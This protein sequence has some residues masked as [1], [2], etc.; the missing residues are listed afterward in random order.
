MHTRSKVKVAGG[1]SALV[2]VLSACASGSSGGSTAASSSGAASSCAKGSGPIVIASVTDLSGAQSP[3]GV[4]ENQGVKL[5]AQE[6][7]DAGGLLGGRKI[8][9]QNFDTQTSPD[10]GVPQATAAVAAKPAAIIGGEISD[11][12]IAGTNISHR[13]GIPWL[14]PGGTA[15]QITGRGFTDVFQ[16]NPN[17]T[18]SAQGYHDVMAFV[19]DKLGVGNK[20]SISVSDTTYGQNL[21]A[22]FTAINDKS[23]KFD[24]V[25]KVSY[26]LSTTDLS[27]IATRMVQPAPDILYNEGYPADGV[28]LGGLF[29]DKVNTTAKVYL[30]T[31]A[32]ATVLKTLGAKANGMLLLGVMDP[33]VKG[34]P[35]SFTDFQD[36]YLKAYPSPNGINGQ[37]FSG[38]TA[39]R[40]VEQAIK[41]AGCADPAEVA[42]ALH[43]VKL[44][45]TTGNI[46]P[47]DEL[48]FDTNGA[49]S[50]PPQFY[51]QVQDGKAVVIYPSSVAT[52]TPIPYRG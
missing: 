38:Y 6:I 25:N 22:A 33:T 17:T 18:Q 14:T 29:T 20:T 5:A 27:A 26:P 15:T 37:A 28:N 16:I 42:K 45:H 7:N 1:V 9:V 40:F 4:A 8:D 23:K 19:A 11:T 39:M 49:Q 2:L 13:A 52:G 24:V 36:A 32:Q 3:L 51:S 41:S 43:S 10:Q 47:Q 31:A 44:T 48:S 21:D 46:Y 30:S 50:H 12:V 34:A 35:K